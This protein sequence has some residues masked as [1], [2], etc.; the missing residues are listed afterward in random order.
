MKATL[1]EARLDK[2]LVKTQAATIGQ[3]ASTSKVKIAVL[4]RESDKAHGLSAIIR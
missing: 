2:P 4:D 3:H 1:A